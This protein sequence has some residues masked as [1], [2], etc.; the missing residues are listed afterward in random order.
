MVFCDLIVHQSVSGIHSGD[1]IEVFGYLVKS[2]P[3]SNPG[4]FDY[5]KFYRGKAKRAFVHVYQAKSVR[6][7]DSGNWFTV[8]WI[9][10]LRAQIKRINLAICFKSGVGVC[11]RNFTWQSRAV[12]T[13]SPSTISRNRHCSS[14]GNLRA[15]CGD[16]SRGIFLFFSCRNF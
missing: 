4:G 13:R 14:V 5:Q 8:R 11:L 10:S 15:T 7:S 16:F 9:S 12:I 3:P 1:Q 2:S 6:V